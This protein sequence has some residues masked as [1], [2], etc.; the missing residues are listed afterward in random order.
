VLL[1]L[2]VPWS[3][4]LLWALVSA[5]RSNHHAPTAAGKLRVLL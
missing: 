2:C 1:M 3:L 5:P 4:F